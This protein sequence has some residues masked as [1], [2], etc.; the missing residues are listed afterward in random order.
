MK[1]HIDVLSPQ[2]FCEPNMVKEL[3]GLSKQ[4]G[5]KPVLVADFGNWC[6]T[7]R[8]PQRKSCPKPQ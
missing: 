6:R 8:N 1:D 4:C 7:E 3:E 2:Y 5:G